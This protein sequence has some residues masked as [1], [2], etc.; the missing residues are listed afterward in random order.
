MCGIRSPVTT[1]W[2][3]AFVQALEEVIVSNIA[4]G[5]RIAGHPGNRLG[6]QHTAEVRGGKVSHP[7]ENATY[8]VRAQWNPVGRV[9]IA[10]RILFDVICGFQYQLFGREHRHTSPGAGIQDTLPVR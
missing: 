6:C 5:Q 8:I 9:M 7:P 2:R 4:R 1:I 10:A 3:I